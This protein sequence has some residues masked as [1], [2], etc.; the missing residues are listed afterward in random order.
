MDKEPGILEAAFFVAAFTEAQ[1]EVLD[2]TGENVPIEAFSYVNVVNS[3]RS[4][5]NSFES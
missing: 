2:S 3:G 4:L 5:P 1:V